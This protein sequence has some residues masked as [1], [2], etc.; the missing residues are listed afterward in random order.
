MQSVFSLRPQIFNGNLTSICY[1][2]GTLDVV[3]LPARLRSAG[4]GAAPP[5]PA[6]FRG[7][8]APRAAAPRVPRAPRRGRFRSRG[9]TH[10][11]QLRVSPAPAA[12]RP[13]PPARVPR[14]GMQ[15]GDEISGVGPAPRRA[16][17]R[18]CPEPDSRRGCATRSPGT[19][20]RTRL[21]KRYVRGRVPDP[22]RGAPRGVSEMHVGTHV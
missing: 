14:D 18:G 11:G 16:K 6:R 19:S 3:G 2:R 10:R 22:A 13:A 9:E 20:S 5:A 15:G 4:R 1:N 21:R 17:C 7:A 8:G 12:P